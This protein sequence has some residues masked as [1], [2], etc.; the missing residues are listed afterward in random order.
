[1]LHVSIQEGFDAL[2][3]GKIDKGNDSF[4]RFLSSLFILGG[5]QEFQIRVGSRVKVISNDIELLGTVVQHFRFEQTAS[6]KMDDWRQQ[7]P[8]Q[9]DIND[10]QVIEQVFFSFSF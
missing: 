6:V 10:F 4:K 1:M 3:G 5:F 8:I 2:K 9:M 7:A